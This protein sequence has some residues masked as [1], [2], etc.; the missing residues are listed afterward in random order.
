MLTI[1]W[2]SLSRFCEKTGINETERDILIRSI[3]TLAIPPIVVFVVALRRD[4]GRSRLERILAMTLVVRACRDLANLL[5]IDS[6]FPDEQR[7]T[8]R[9]TKSLGKRKNKK[10]RRSRR[11]RPAKPAFHQ[12]RSV[13]ADE[14]AEPK[15]SSADKGDESPDQVGL[16]AASSPGEGSLSLRHD[17]ACEGQI[18][19]HPTKLNPEAREFIP[20]GD[21][22]ALADKRSESEPAAPQSRLTSTATSPPNKVGS[23]LR[24]DRDWEGRIKECTAILDPEA[25]EFFPSEVRHVDSCSQRVPSSSTPQEC[26]CLPG[27]RGTISE[28]GSGYYAVLKDWV[29]PPT[30]ED[31]V[32]EITPDPSLLDKCA[33]V[34][35]DEN[36]LPP[37]AAVNLTARPTLVK[38]SYW[39]LR[40]V[41]RMK[42]HKKRGDCRDTSAGDS[43]R[44]ESDRRA[45]STVGWLPTI[46]D[47]P[48]DWASPSPPT[49]GAAND[50]TSSG[51]APPAASW[52]RPAPETAEY[53]APTPAPP[54][55]S[56]QGP[57]PKETAEEFRSYVTADTKRL[58][59][60][61]FVQ[62]VKETR[63]RSDISNLENVHHKAK[64][65]LKHYRYRGAPVKLSTEPW[66]RDR[67]DQALQRGAHKSCLGHIN[68]LEEEFADMRSKGQWI[69]LRACDVKDLPG[70][71]IA[72]P[73][74]IEQDGRRPR[75]IVDFTFNGVNSETLPPAAMEAMQF[76]H[77][78]DRILREILLADPAL[79]PV[80]LIKVDL[81]DGFYRVDLNIEDIPKL[82]MVL[83]MKEGDGTPHRL[84]ASSTNGV[85]EQ[86]TYLLVLHRDDHRPCQSASGR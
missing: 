34:G 18:E 60:V 26:P 2:Q 65:L 21:G 9:Q 86:P 48:S 42:R 31:E 23:P 41:T 78:L 77:A 25:R 80:R 40:N 52:L 4:N 74:V 72:P 1:V 79:G 16:S 45:P 70:L 53:L 68:F 76:G 20:S 24:R 43:S 19:E 63:Q 55:A 84:P 81:S 54:V 32:E 75:T 27:V 8:P 50:N 44:L 14:R 10:A 13:L 15:S 11:P 6:S 64:P 46:E 22:S 3:G 51:P 57:A 85:E 35:P 82:G 56:N 37:A 12:K 7:D 47:D 71:R 62:L 33:E 59:E 49:R 69:V 30:G 67:I 39:D 36:F 61:G 83:P 28:E 17:S 58:H 38:R 66:H 29:D 5:A 73:G